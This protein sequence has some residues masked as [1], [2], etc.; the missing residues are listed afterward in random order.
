[1]PFRPIGSSTEAIWGFVKFLD[2]V[3]ICC[4]RYCTIC[5]GGLSFAAPSSAHE[6][7]GAQICGFV[8]RLVFL[9]DVLVWF[10][11]LFVRKKE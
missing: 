6:C 7:L 3:E 9:V 10:D 2:R 8:L 5:S 1:M 11:L 4:R